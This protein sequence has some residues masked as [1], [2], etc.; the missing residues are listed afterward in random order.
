MKGSVYDKENILE[1]NKL[2]ADFM[3]Y[4]YIPFN[5]ENDERAG[6]WHKKTPDVFLKLGSSQT[7]KMSYRYFL[8]R[9]HTDLEYFN[10]YDASM[11]VL[12]KIEKMGYTSSLKTN[13]FRINP[14]FGEYYEEIIRVSFTSDGY[15]TYRYLENKIDLDRENI[16]IQ[17]NH[18]IW[19]GLVEFIKWYNKNVKI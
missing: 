11:N 10:S 13:Y 18:A 4:R 16:E 3:G 8:C 17:K 19:L 12:D 5:N 9:R 2:I 7:S 14:V 1:G 15:F 6:W